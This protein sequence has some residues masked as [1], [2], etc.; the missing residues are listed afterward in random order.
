MLP[1]AAAR[2]VP[3]GSLPWEGFVGV[4]TMP[5]LGN[6]QVHPLTAVRPVPKTKL[7]V[8]G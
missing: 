2:P 1:L 5:R 6:A 8:N 3:E 7:N 4:G